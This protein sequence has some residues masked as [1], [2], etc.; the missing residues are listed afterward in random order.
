MLDQCDP[1]GYGVLCQIQ[2]RGPNLGFIMQAAMWL[3]LGGVFLVVVNYSIQR[4]R[5]RLNP[6]LS[7]DRWSE[8]DAMASLA[9]NSQLTDEERKI[10]RRAMAAKALKAQNAGEPD[11]SAS[12]GSQRG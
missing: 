7:R 11:G 6:D 12:V 8:I 10:I 2:G 9:D 3:F 4:I 5:R 1:A